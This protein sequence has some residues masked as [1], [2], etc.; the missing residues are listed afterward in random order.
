E[1]VLRAFH[2]YTWTPT[3]MRGLVNFESRMNGLGVGLA[4]LAC[5]QDAFHA[6]AWIFYAY[7]WMIKASGGLG[8]V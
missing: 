7:A 2:T 6:Y 8:H 3:P 4:W 5:Y 1:H